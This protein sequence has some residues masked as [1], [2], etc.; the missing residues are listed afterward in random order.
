MDCFGAMENPGLIT[1]RTD[2]LQLGDEVRGS[3]AEDVLNV[4]AHEVAHIWYGDLVTMKWWDD[5]WLNEAFATWMAQTILRTEFPQYES[6]LKL[7]QSAALA[8][9]QRTTSKAIRRTVRNTEEI[10]D[11]MGLNYSKGH[12]ILN[13]LEEYVGSEM[14]R[15]SI[16]RY[17]QKYA[18]S[19]A[20]ERDLWNVISETSGLD[21]AS[22]ASDYLNQPGFAK[23]E[24][25]RDGQVSQQRFVSYGRTA[26]DLDWQVPLK[27]KY[28]KDHKILETS[29]LLK[30]QAG[31]ID[32]PANTDWIFPD[33]GGNGYFRWVTDSTQFYNLI[34]DA[35][36]LTDRERIALLSNSKALLD[37]GNLSLADY[38]F[39][40]DKLL[41]DEHPLVFLPALEA[42][43]DIGDSFTDSDSA[44]MFARFVDDSLASRFLEV[45]TDTRDQDSEAIIQMRP[46]LMR[47]LG[48]YG[49]DARVR[50]AA[51]KLA[52][53]YLESP[54]SVSADLGR[55]A[56]RVTA[57]S[58]D[59]GLYSQYQKAY[60]Q[61]SSADFKSN[62]LSS[63][64]FDNEKIIKEHL[65]FSMSSAV[66]AGD[67]LTGLTLYAAT[68]EDN[69][70][71]YDWLDDNLEALL[72]KIPQYR[73][74]Q[75]P[76]Y[77][78][79][80]CNQ[81]NLDKLKAFFEPLGDAYSVSLAKAVETGEN[82]IGRKRR[83][84]E[85]LVQFLDQYSDKKASL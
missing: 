63:I 29:Y 4:V 48:Q 12:S 51:A 23:I 70:P 43:K 32:V 45:G 25:G 35:D 2:Y 18:W 85:A 73:H 13:M 40:L 7:P 34:D 71:L 20:T 3:K 49:T 37:A 69:A 6:S 10:M 82:C 83:E 80:T 14:L 36:K 46:R 61:S 19:N 30:E 84:R 55:E 17:I 38:L 28:K 66:A 58:D 21:V 27:V 24:I 77:M 47:V 39:A 59:G 41:K 31:V 60:L 42:L 54:T 50:E 78:A 15:K 53:Q 65:D 52:R 16:R 64:Y 68:L 81:A 33:A 9:D 5:L 72:N 76:Q 62:V 11:G 22:V 44:P 67:A 26:P 8:A 56:L 74:A 57:L 79:P 75:L 1:Y